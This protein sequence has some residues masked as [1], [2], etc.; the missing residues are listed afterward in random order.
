V[1]AYKCDLAD[2]EAVKRMHAQIVSDLG[3]I[4]IL[5]NNAGVAK[6]IGDGGITDIDIATFE[7]T[8][9]VN[10]GSAYLLTQLC[11]PAMEK[12]KWGRI[13]FNSSV[14]AFTGGVVGPHYASSKSALHGL[15]HWLSNK[16]AKEGITTNGIAPALIEGTIM[17]PGDS[18]TLKSKIPVGRLG[19]PDEVADIVLLMAN[20]GYISNKV[21]GVDG[22]LYPY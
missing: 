2:F 8:W 19:T 20:N 6:F 5:F 14:A 22:G 4:D 21:W 7:F 3:D 12:K 16:Y 10:T 17:L 1:K 9:R 13:I 18:S 11:V 15:I